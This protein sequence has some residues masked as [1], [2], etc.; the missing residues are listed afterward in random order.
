[1]NKIGIIGAMEEEVE[2]LRKEIASME[3]H[4]FANITFYTGRIVEK[5]IV[6]VTCGIGKV[7]AAICTQILINKFGVSHIINTG[8]AGGISKDTD[9][10]D[11]VIASELL[12]HDFDVTAFGYD[13]GIIPRMDTSLFKGDDK[14][15]ELAQCVAREKLIESSV[16]VKRIIT[17]D[18]FINHAHIKEKGLDVFDAYA[19]EMEST[20]I[21]H[22]AYLNKIPFVIIRAISDKAD[23]TANIDFNEFV[24]KAAKNS[25]DIVLEMIQKI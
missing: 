4:N 14:L 2:I 8:V 22:T 11:I 16:Y 19:V 24:H 15:I 1:M 10:G 5:D 6:L 21:A 3:Q 23:G 12:Y 13:K 18:Q 17:G 7:N 9:I 25:A 20:A